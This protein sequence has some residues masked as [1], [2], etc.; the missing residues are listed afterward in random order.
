MSVQDNKQDQDKSCQVIIHALSSES[1]QGIKKDVESHLEISPE[2][3][4]FPVLSYT[5]SLGNCDIQQKT[6]NDLLSFDKD[7]RLWQGRVFNHHFD[8]RWVRNPSN[9]NSSW[10]AWL[11]VEFCHTSMIDKV[12][13]PQANIQYQ[14]IRK[15]KKYYLNGLFKEEAS[16]GRFIFTEM[17]YPDKE[18]K[19]PLPNKP[20]DKER[21][22]LTVYEYERLMPTDWTDITDDCVQEYLDQPLLIAH[23]FVKLGADTS[24]RSDVKRG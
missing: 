21:A 23:R 10:Q 20:K 16:D 18:F 14:A 7:Q 17:R 8:L 4:Q 13:T 2:K 9:S 15:E 11:T 12:L 1:W 5:E 3:S 24:K 22:F 19:Y 6:W